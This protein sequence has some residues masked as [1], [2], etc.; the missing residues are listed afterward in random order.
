MCSIQ[1]KLQYY[2]GQC[3]YWPI[4]ETQCNCIVSNDVHRCE[5]MNTVNVTGTNEQSGFKS[6]LDR[7]VTKSKTQLSTRMSWH[8]NGDT[9][10]YPV[11]AKT[12]LRWEKLKIEICLW[13]VMG[14]Y[15]LHF[16]FSAFDC[17]AFLCAVHQ[18]F[19]SSSSLFLSLLSFYPI[20]FEHLCLSFLLS[21]LLCWS[22]VISFCL[23]LVLCLSLC[24]IFLSV[25][26][27]L[28]T[29]PT[30]I[31]MQPK[32][33]EIL[34]GLMT[35]NRKCCTWVLHYFTFNTNLPAYIW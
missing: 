16:E 10:C 8:V 1:E 20:S 21:A 26:C 33:L 28:S 29:S 4:S 35:I 7:I 13:Y 34:H 23:S 3:C 5:I 12:I 17:E 22:V 6:S 14:Y 24:L 2:L 19:P 25:S 27:S 18:T 30:Q 15:S 31:G 9:R 32:C 11:S